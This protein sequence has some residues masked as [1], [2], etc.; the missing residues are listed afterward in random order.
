M[1]NKRRNVLLP[2]KKVCALPEG[3]CKT[4]VRMVSCARTHV[5][6]WGQVCPQIKALM[7]EGFQRL[8]TQ[9]GKKSAWEETTMSDYTQHCL[10]R[11]DHHNYR[12]VAGLSC[13]V[14]HTHKRTHKY[15]HTHTHNNT[16]TP[17]WQE[18][19]VS[20]S[21]SVRVPASPPWAWGLLR[22]SP[23][24]HCYCI[25]L[26]FHVPAS[27]IQLT[28]RTQCG[29]PQPTAWSRWDGCPIHPAC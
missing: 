27:R 6:V 18:G 22:Y 20:L 10:S 21:A 7:Y 4:C 14:I 24:P 19:K 17:S 9:G 2:H 29:G 12:D 1:E 15:T 28:P 5:Y 23:L 8:K 25:Y 13:T 11:T 16:H 26:Q 3:V